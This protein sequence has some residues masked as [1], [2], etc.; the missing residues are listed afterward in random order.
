MALEQRIEALKKRHE[1]SEAKLHAEECRPS[2]DV[3]LIQQLKREKL[4]LKDEIENLIGE[5]VEAA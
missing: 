3:A 2:P 4:L 1:Q 5:K